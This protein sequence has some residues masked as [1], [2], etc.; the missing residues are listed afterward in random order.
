MIQQHMYTRERRGLYRQFEGYDTVAKSSDLADAFVKEAIHPYCVY[1]PGSST[2]AITLV[3]YSCGR[4]LLGQAVHVPADFTGQRAAFFA[5]NFIMPSEAV[6]DVLD[7]MR[8]ENIIF[9]NSYDIE[10]G[11]VL[12][13]L[14]NLPMGMASG[15]EIAIDEGL[16]YRI[17]SCVTESIRGV[18]KTY[19]L[20]PHVQDFHRYVCELLA[21]LY[22]CLPEGMKHLLGFCTYAREPQQGKGI[23]LYFLR[24]DEVRAGDSRMAGD[25]VVDAEYENGGEMSDIS[26]DSAQFFSTRIQQLSPSHFFS[27]MYFWRKRVPSQCENLDEIELAWMDANIDRLSQSQLMAITDAFIKRGKRGK[28]PTMYVMLSILKIACAKIMKSNQDSFDMRYFLGSYMLPP[29]CRERIIQNIRRL[30]YDT[31]RT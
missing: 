10:R 2:K 1:P 7:D 27:E 11:G 5:H 6:S 13:A 12:D 18:K 9:E 28:N 14:Q 31:S 23:H 3:H 20:V 19:V 24:K 25:F 21:Q 30:C 26:Y 15:S 22:Q 8:L 17:A 4:M 16:I 29:A